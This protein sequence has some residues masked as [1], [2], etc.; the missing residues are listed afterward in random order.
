MKQSL[1][2]AGK[3]PSPSLINQETQE[4]TRCI[5]LQRECIWSPDLSVI[6]IKN[7]QSSTAKMPSSL[8]GLTGQNFVIEFPNVDRATIP[9]LHHFI[10]YC[11]RF[12]AFSNDNEGNPFQEELVP[13]ASSSPALLNAIAAL[14]AGHLARSQKQVHEVMATNHYAKALREMNS[15]LSDGVVARSD[16]ILGACLML[17]VYEVCRSSITSYCCTLC[18]CQSFCITSVFYS[19]KLIQHCTALKDSTLALPNYFSSYTFSLD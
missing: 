9:Y 7:R 10:T 1:V 19:V 4:Y 3:S 5:R 8:S 17:C 12:L 6:P 13:L 11:S 2:A 15:S 18:L 14:A 16:S